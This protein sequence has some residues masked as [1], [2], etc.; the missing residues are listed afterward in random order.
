[1]QDTKY[2]LDST[3][4]RGALVTVIPAVVLIVKMFGVQI[5]NG[6]QQNLIDGVTAIAGLI[7]TVVAIIGRFRATKQL[8]T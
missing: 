5:G 6:E 1:M 4:I 2:W 7:G 3:T 8:T